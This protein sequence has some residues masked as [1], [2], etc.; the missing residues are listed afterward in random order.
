[1]RVQKTVRFLHFELPWPVDLTSKYVLSPS[2]PSA[3]AS[4]P[5]I[6][7]GLLTSLINLLNGLAAYVAYSS[8][9]ESFKKHKSDHVTLPL[10]TLP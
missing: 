5:D 3:P 9:R 2:M 6:I 1:M 8:Q 7:I 4:F 10:K